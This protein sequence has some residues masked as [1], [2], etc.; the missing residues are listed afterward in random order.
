MTDIVPG[1]ILKYL[2]V[3]KDRKV[4]IGL[5]VILMGLVI[6]LVWGSS[7]GSKGTNLTQDIVKG[8]VI[9]TITANGAVEDENSIPLGFKNSAALKSIYVKEGQ[10]VKKGDLLAEQEESDARAQYQQQLANLKAAEARLALA[11]AGAREEDVRQAEENVLVARLSKEQSKSNYDRYAILFDQGA[12]SAADKEKAEYDYKLAESK[13]NQVQEQLKI[14]YSGSRP[15]DIMVNE[16]QVESAHAQLQLAKNN[17]DATKLTAPSDG[18]IGQVSAVVGQRTSDSGLITLISD[19]LQI[20]AQVNEADIGRAAVGQQAFF[21]VNSFPNRK[22]TGVV[23]S[24]SPKAVTIAN[25][26]LYEVIIS[27]D[28]QETALKVGMPANVSII[29]DQKTDVTL[30]PKIAVSYAFQEAQKLSGRQGQTGTQDEGGSERQGNIR[31]EG[32]GGANNL[33]GGTKQV[34]VLVMKN[35]KPV[36]EQVQVGI[37]DNTNYEVLDGLKE[38][39][40]VV[41]GST[42]PSTAAAGSQT[43]GAIRIGNPPGNQR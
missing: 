3:L 15:E 10:R 29:V 32:S 25:V 22:F 31:R 1:K 20:R 13:Y 2:P 30:L 16:S 12:I 34:P 24:I 7:L 4:L 41:I 26:Q 18:V 19:R 43:P 37:S 11:K 39:E 9:N 33:N 36:L 28:Q 27:L 5:I 21:S 14:L 35:G 23:E 17:L 38:G 6:L 8:D 42:A 40:R